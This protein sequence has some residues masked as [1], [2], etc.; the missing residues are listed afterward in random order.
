[1]YALPVPHVSLF[2]FVGYGLIGIGLITLAAVGIGAGVIA[3]RRRKAGDTWANG[4]SPADDDAA[5]DEARR[6]RIL[7]DDREHDFAGW[8]ALSP[9]QPDTRTV[10]EHAREVTPFDARTTG[11]VAAEPVDG[12]VEPAEVAEH[13]AP[14]AGSVASI[15]AIGEDTK[16][17][18]PVALAALERAEEAAYAEAEQRAVDS[19]FTGLD[20][21]LDRF[22]ER[23]VRAD[24]WLYYLHGDH[25]SECPHC[26]LALE[27]ISDEYRMLSTH[28]S[29][30]PRAEL[31]AMLA[32]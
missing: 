27:A 14:G 29:E 20:A 12:P 2:Q 5:A 23:T 18:G 30:I 28:T 13:V 24:N 26:T 32:A 3:A 4:A 16:L 31:D 8:M 6:M 9:V 21:A 7:I 19:Y 10:E 25:P 11:S 15:A 17:R 22:R 1:M